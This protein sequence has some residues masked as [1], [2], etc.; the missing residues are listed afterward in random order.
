MSVATFE[1]A[2]AKLESASTDCDRVATGNFDPMLFPL[3]LKRAAVVVLEINDWARSSLP[4]GAQ[5]DVV[6]EKVNEL[7]SA[8][9]RLKAAMKPHVEYIDSM[10]PK[11]ETANEALAVLAR[12]TKRSRL[13]VHSRE[14]APGLIKFAALSMH[15]VQE[16][17]K[18]ASPTE[19][20]KA[21]IAVETDALRA[22][23]LKLRK[24]MGYG[25]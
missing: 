16:W 25:T 13:S 1:D 6:V 9:E 4:S 21:A 8:A 15:V 18:T 10:T 12:A 3:T 23:Y 22:E 5:R 20:E 14:A 2:V 11:V 24:V 7:R 17:R 19:A